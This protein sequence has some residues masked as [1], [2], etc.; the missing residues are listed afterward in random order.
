MT[1]G[2]CSNHLLA[3]TLLEV[4]L[5]I[6]CT[7]VVVWFMIPSHPGLSKAQEEVRSKAQRAACVYIAWRLCDLESQ[8]RNNHREISRTALAEYLSDPRLGP[9]LDL[10]GSPDKVANALLTE[11]IFLQESYDQIS[12]D[13][14]VVAGKSEETLA[15]RRL[16]LAV[17]R[18]GRIIAV[19]TD[20]PLVGSSAVR[21][22]ESAYNV[23]L[24][25]NLRRRIDDND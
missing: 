7:L 25:G 17:L 24:G 14:I 16:K 2:S 10:E 12:D 23:T 5:A 21:W 6:A 13:V 3:L 4:S 20:K 22:L 8:G 19:R 18:D 15:G 9:I 11:Y 1:K